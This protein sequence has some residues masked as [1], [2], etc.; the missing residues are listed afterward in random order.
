MAVEEKVEQRKER[1]KERMKK[2][3][4]DNVE[5]IKAYQKEWRAKNAQSIT[6]YQKRY[7]EE[8]RSRDENSKKCWKRN[9]KRNYG[10]T[11][12]DFNAMWKQQKGKCA[13]CDIELQPRGRT[14]DSVVVD[15]NHAT[16]EVRGL[17]CR[18]CNHGIGH[19]KDD[20]LILK[21]A[22]KYLFENGNYSHL[23]K[24]EK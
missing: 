1:T 11:P 21:F 24:D 8:Y 15:H 6:E 5:H 20:P 18:S 7:Q 22:A 2:W 9:L 16:G 10:L 13:I 3:R 19:F 14:T 4:S 12:N 23:K 17:L